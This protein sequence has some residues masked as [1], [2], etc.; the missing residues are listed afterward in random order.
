METKEAIEILKETGEYL[1]Y[2][3]GTDSYDQRCKL[4]DAAKVLES[5]VIS[6]MPTMEEAQKQV[7]KMCINEDQGEG[8]GMCFRWLISLAKTSNKQ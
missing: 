3:V 7:V 1:N 4:F 6:K 2:H 5:H 8:F